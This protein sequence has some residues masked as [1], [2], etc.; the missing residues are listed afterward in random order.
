M[1]LDLDFVRLMVDNR[2]NLW[3]QKDYTQ[4]DRLEVFLIYFAIPLCLSWAVLLSYAQYVGLLD[5]FGLFTMYKSPARID[6]E[7]KTDVT[8]GSVAGVD[9]AKEELEEIVDFLKEPLRYTEMGAKLPKG[10]LLNG[11][12]G[13]GKTLLAKAVA[14]EAGVPFISIS[15]SEFIQEYP[16]VGAA[17]VRDLFAQAKKVAPCIVFIDELDSVGRERNKG[18]I[19]PAQEERQQTVNQLL[20]EMDGYEGAKGIIVLAATNLPDVIDKALIRPGRFDR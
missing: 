1:D 4:L 11:P 10:A 16:G 19:D 8:F 6:M 7:P 5:A 20:V 13:T 18:A 14:G 17:R 9:D 2:V 3:L 15:A 12:P